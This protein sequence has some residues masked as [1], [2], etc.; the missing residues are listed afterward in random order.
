MPLTLSSEQKQL[1]DRSLQVIDKVEALFTEAENLFPD[2]TPDVAGIKQQLTNPF[3]IFICGEF[4]AGKSSLLNQLGDNSI[5]PVGILP[6]TQDI[7]SYNPEGLGGLRFIDSP[8]TNSIIEQ[9]QE[10]TENY[11]KQ[12]DIILFVSSVERPLSKS[13]QDF[14]TLVDRT[15]SRKVI[16][17]IN[18]IDLINPEQL[19]E[20]SNYISQGLKDIFPD[21]PPLFTISS[22]TGQ[23]MDELKDFLLA[24]LEEGEK[25]KLKLQGPQNS[26]L[27]YLEQLEQKSQNIKTKLEKEKAVLDRTLR[28]IQDRLEEYKILFGI[29]QGNINELFR[30]LLQAVS[31]V[32]DQKISFTSAAKKRVTNEEDSLEEKLTKAIE[33]A[34]LDDNLK[35]I[36]EEATAT[37][38]TY[39]GRIIREATED[40]E[41]AIEI[42]QDNFVIPALDSSQVNTKEIS[43]NIKLAADKGLNSCGRLGVVAAVTGFGGL[44]VFNTVSLDASA[45][46]LSVLFGLLSVNAMPRQRKR[47]KQQ[48]EANFNEL[49]QNYVNTL[50]KSL[51]MEL[52]DCLKKFIDSVQPKQQE[53]ESKIK[54]SES[55]TEKIATLKAEINNILTELQAS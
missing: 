47:V 9:H 53:L 16:V 41:M 13:E 30:V 10:I 12:A 52:N 8:G 34:Q 40:L 15:W 36:F 4:N 27:V 21:L 23:G 38:L 42:G 35:S 25:I 50:W 26:L 7:E 54:I 14:L 3:S 6:T 51:A 11:L 29:F 28:R 22:Q 43:E 55:L 46:V 45:F 32:I 48:L 17:A 37:F 5:A 44:T 20:V 33:E 39:R 1:F 2:F 49:K 24:F 18:K 31:K 19:E